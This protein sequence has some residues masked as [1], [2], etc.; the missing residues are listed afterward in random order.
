MNQHPIIQEDISKI[1]HADIDW[2]RFKDSHVL[3]SGAAG[4]LPAYMIYAL[5]EWSEAN[6]ANVRVTALVRN[7]EKAVKKFRKFITS[8]SLNLIVQDVCDPF[9]HTFNCDWIIHA[10]SQASPKF[11]GIDP[12]GTALANSLGTYRLLEF[13]KSNPLKG[14]LFFSTSEVYGQLEPDR[15]PIS[16]SSYGNIDPTL[17]RS[18]YSESKRF[19]ETLCVSYA[20]QFEVP[21]KIVR[22]FHTYGPGMD[23]NDGRVFADFVSD[24]V[25]KR[26]IVLKSKG[27]ATRAFCYLTD[28]VIGFYKILLE[29]EI[30][31]PY[32]I[33]NPDAEISIAD[34]ASTLTALYPE[35]NLQ[36]RFNEVV[37]SLEYIPSQVQ[38][39]SP[40]IEKA[41]NLGWTPQISISEGF[42]RTIDFYLTQ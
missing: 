14:F 42:R 24:I 38:R 17:V 34:L 3:V 37:H 13:A 26:D 9:E 22:P 21:V 5:L 41:K 27:T 31:A 7:Y 25:H 1:N 18:C 32:N 28:A 6:D 16:E 11:Y 35:F 29:G 10:A 39:N 23:L 4:F 2:Q 15:I 12:V 40:N 36:L 8:G 19:G 20:H 33:G 30:A